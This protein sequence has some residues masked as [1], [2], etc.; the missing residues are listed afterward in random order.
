MYQEVGVSTQ[1]CKEPNLLAALLSSATP[2]TYR[3]LGIQV[4]SQ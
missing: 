4:H 1:A 3:P 2:T